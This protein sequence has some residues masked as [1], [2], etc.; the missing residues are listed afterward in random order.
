MPCHDPE[1][2]DENRAARSSLKESQSEANT[3]RALCNSLTDLLCMAGRAHY[4][5]L[6]PDA[7]VTQW[8]EQHAEM[9]RCRGEAWSYSRSRTAA[10]ESHSVPGLERAIAE[11][12][13]YE[14]RL[15]KGKSIAW[16]PGTRCDM[17]A[18]A[19]AAAKPIMHILKDWMQPSV[20][21]HTDDLS[22][23]VTKAQLDLALK[24]YDFKYEDS[25]GVVGNEVQFFARRV[26]LNVL[27][28]GI[29]IDEDKEK[30][31]AEIW[32]KLSGT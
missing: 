30:D 7:K 24:F 1:L 23:P 14:I 6:V 29:P 25:H 2:A 22:K 15:A 8:W 19:M 27:K 31:A 3:L 17:H 4:A 18:R 10:S 11:I 5:G 32:R 9:D 16:Q 20:A 21:A 12:I 13:F 26:I 28:N